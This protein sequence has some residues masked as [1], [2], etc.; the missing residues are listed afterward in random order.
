MPHPVTAAEVA[1]LERELARKK[2]AL[3][4]DRG[5]SER[6]RGAAITTILAAMKLLLRHGRTPGDLAT[7][8]ELS[9]RSVHRLLNAFE[10]AGIK[11]ESER[12]GREVY[13][14]LSADVVKK[15]L[16]L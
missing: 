13:Y 8:L 9:R 11:L 4:R 7:D 5:G 1:K 16:G 10:S 3:K 12:S 2:A 14:R 6:E 15:E